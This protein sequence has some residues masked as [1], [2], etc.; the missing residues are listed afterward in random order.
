VQLP[1]YEKGPNGGR[2][3]YQIVEGNCDVVIVEGHQ[4]YSQEAILNLLNGKTKFF[5]TA[6]KETVLDR[7][8]KTYGIESTDIIDQLV[9]SM[10][11]DIVPLAGK[12]DFILDTTKNSPRE[13][14][15]E[16]LKHMDENNSKQGI[17]SRLWWECFWYDPA[18][19]FGPPR[20]EL[21]DLIVGEGNRK[22][23]LTVVDVA[24]GDGR[25]AVSIAKAGC[26]VE[27]VE[28]TTTGVE[29]IKETP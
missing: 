5:L 9:V 17:H 11:S 4:L 19:N 21:V 15:L 3:G 2:K 24:S 7:R 12:A 28:L 29:R 1:I 26:E 27:A 13:L 16:I 25:Y 14:A 23:K 6:D 20:K 10:N 8:A 18:K 22:E